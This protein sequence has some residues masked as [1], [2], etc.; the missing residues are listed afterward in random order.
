MFGGGVGWPSGR[1]GW[2]RLNKE[3]PALTNAE[4]FYA[5][6]ANRQLPLINRFPAQMDQEQEISTRPTICHVLHTLHVGGGEILAR[7]FAI[8]NSDCFRPVFALLDEIGSLG[9]ELRREGYVVEVINRKPGFDFGCARRLGKFLSRES[10][11][12]I[13]AHQY[14]PLFYSCLARLPTRRIPILFTEHGRDYPDY[15]RWKR[16]WANRSLLTKKDR[17]VAVG[18]Y[19][20]KALVEFEGL[21][22]DRVDVIYNGRDLRKFVPDQSLR[23]RIR[24][25]LGLSHDGFVVVQVARLD[26]L[27]DHPTA[28]R[29][30]ARLK[31]ELP[32]CTLLIVGDG[33]ERKHVQDLVEKHGLGSCVRMLGERS[34]VAQLLQAADLFLLTSVSE[35][36]PLT[37]IEAMAT[38]LPCVATRVGGIPEIV[39]DGETGFLAYSGNH[40]E[41]TRHIV[42]LA[43]DPVLRERFG[44]AGR[45]RVV[46]RFD[47]LAMLES[48]KGLYCE[49]A[50]THSAAGRDCN[51]THERQA[52]FSRI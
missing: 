22:E 44:K 12:V 36:I 4:C 25:Q 16:V 24:D 18:E 7:N 26:R 1:G 52:T 49:M 9:E 29:V 42:R 10:V 8:E 23:V 38:A 33:E 32:H 45:A 50:S 14:A 37:L 35:G 3:A 6:G 17:F 19:V 39:I 27:K 47:E 21:P 5:I 15:R 48:Y 40:L 11:A 31:E 43:A 20:R 13:H 2:L 41:L 51:H 46:N 28:L 34:D 30:M